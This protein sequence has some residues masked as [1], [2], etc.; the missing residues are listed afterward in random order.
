MKEQTAFFELIINILDNKQTDSN[1]IIGGDFNVALDINLDCHGS[2]PFQK[3]SAKTF[4]D[5]CLSN[6][7]VDI[8]RIRNPTEKCF[9]WRQKN[10]L[11]QRRLDYWLISD[12]LQ[13]EIDSALTKTAIKSDHS[14]I[15]L[16]LSSGENQ[17]H[18]LS[19]WRFN[20]SLVDDAIYA[21]MINE[22]YPLWLQ[23]FSE[24]TDKRVLWD[25]IAKQQNQ[26]PE[27]TDKTSQ[28]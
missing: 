25:I 21:K 28:N 26:S 5:L 15:I 3:E 10:P 14:A 23:E 13:E 24:I 1:I 27:E 18:G 22:S 2:N 8:W 11:I 16:K 17:K 12:S 6:D 4:K 19:Y 7:L 20:S 9:T